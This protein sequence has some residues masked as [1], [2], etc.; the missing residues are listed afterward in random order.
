MKTREVN[1]TTATNDEHLHQIL[2]LQKINLP[3]NL[4]QQEREQEGFVTVDHDFET[5]KKMNS[6]YPHVIAL[7]GDQLVGYALVMLKSIRNDIDILKPMFEKIGG[8]TYNSVPLSNSNY[9]VMGQVCVDKDYRGQGIFYKMYNHLKA[10]TQH[11]FD[12]LITEVSSLNTRS[13][14]AHEKHGFTNILS[15]NAPDGH[16]WEILLWEFN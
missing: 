2:R 15:Y 6:P 16:S 12:L 10:T 3:K 13:L 9:L 8:L 1:I 4:S 14:K 11:D 5:L 7:D